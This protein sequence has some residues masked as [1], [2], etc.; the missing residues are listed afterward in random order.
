MPVDTVTPD[1]QVD[2]TMFVE[3]GRLRAFKGS[4]NFNIP[5]GIDLKA[6][7]HAVIWCEQF[8]DLVSS[9]KLSYKG[10]CAGAQR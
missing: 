4:Q 9:A 7:G 3:L 1:T 2:K 8:G 6:Y 5:E 10:E